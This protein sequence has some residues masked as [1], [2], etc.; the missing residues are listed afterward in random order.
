MT[1]NPERAAAAYLSGSMS[2]RHRKGFEEHILEC[3]DCWSEMEIGRRGR[4]L[5]EEGRE[6]APQRLRER[7]RMSVEAM[8][9]S[10]HRWRGVALGGAVVAIALATLVATIEWQPQK[11]EQPTEIALL[12]ADFE[13]G[14]SL[15]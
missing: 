1:H 10:K 6:L 2:R 3:E 8:P 15:K 13:S 14:S 4:S 11:P 7:V 5:A 12:V 9:S